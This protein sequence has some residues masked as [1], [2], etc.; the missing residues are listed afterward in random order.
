MSDD[1]NA[2]RDQ[3]IEN[4][5]E[6]P[7]RAI[8]GAGLTPN[9]LVRSLG[10]RADAADSR[11][12]EE[13][14]AIKTAQTMDQVSELMDK[15]I[16]SKFEAKKLRLEALAQKQKSESVAPGFDKTLGEQAQRLEM[17]ALAESEDSKISSFADSFISMIET[18]MGRLDIVTKRI[19]ATKQKIADQKLDGEDRVFESQQALRETDL[20]IALGRKVNMTKRTNRATEG[21]RLTPEGVSGAIRETMAKRRNRLVLEAARIEL[22]ENEKAL[23]AYGDETTGLIGDLTKK[24]NDSAEASKAIRTQLEATKDEAARAKLQAQLA[25]SEKNETESFRDLRSARGERNSLRSGNVAI[26]QRAAENTALVPDEVTLDNLM[27]KLDEVWAK[28]KATV[29]QIDVMKSVGDGLESVLGTISGSLANAFTAMA[30]GAK[31]TKDAMKDMAAGIIKAM[32]DVIA[33]MIAMNAIKSAMN[34]FNLM[35]GGMGGGMAEGG[36]VGDG[37]APRVPMRWTGMATGGMVKHMA[38]GGGVTG[39]ISG[40][41]SVPTMLMPGEFVLQKSAVD[42]LGSDYLHSLNSAANSVVS[43]STPKA[44]AAA[45]SEGSVVNV[46]VVSPDQKPSS[47]GAKDIVAVISDDIERG[48]SIKKLI[49]QVVTNN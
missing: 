35:G 27:F 6:R 41:D 15:A 14:S 17:K 13:K 45:A 49:K 9:I 47:V 3:R 29:G 37:T 23:A 2:I 32:I 24:Y 43:S 39:G 16:A 36:L 34:F 12:N 30:T 42:S 5:N 25:F 11:A 44:G 7:A 1:I 8:Q 26:R 40:R 48:G 28:Y 33:Q 19:N 20:D 18:A 38:R 10:V 21:N 46:W 22:E 4:I 31:S